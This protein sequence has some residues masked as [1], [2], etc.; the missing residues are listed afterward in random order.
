MDEI[1]R[2]CGVIDRCLS[3]RNMAVSVYNNEMIGILYVYI[4]QF[5]SIAA[6]LCTRRVW[7]TSKSAGGMWD[8]LGIKSSRSLSGLGRIAQKRLHPQI[9]I[10]GK[11]PRVGRGGHLH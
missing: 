9:V 2:H 7:P 6:E 3:R 5:V 8:A 4:R 11:A 1:G 10:L